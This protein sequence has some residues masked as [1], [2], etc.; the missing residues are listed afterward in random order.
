ML[1]TPRA[2]VILAALAA[3]APLALAEDWTAP[4]DGVVT[5]KHVDDYVAYLEQLAKFGGTWHARTWYLHTKVEDKALNEASVSRDEIVWARPRVE[6]IAGA[7]MLAKATPETWAKLE[8]RAQDTLAEAQKKIAELTKNGPKELGD[9]DGVLTELRGLEREMGQS[10]V[11]CFKARVG[12]AILEK[13]RAD[14]KDDATRDGLAA[15]ILTQRG[16][17][18]R[19]QDTVLTLAAKLDPAE[20]RRLEIVEKLE[21]VGAT[22]GLKLVQVCSD[23]RLDLEE[24]AAAKKAQGETKLETFPKASV[25]AVKAKQ[26]KLKKALAALGSPTVTAS[27]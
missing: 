15:K 13:E 4:A 5:A 7:L 10:S 25:D 18:D 9:L 23:A 26:E 24:I 8:K 6:E 11:E 14:A 22:D 21:K 20:R 16:H 27:R 19:A 1:R 12:L 3:L 2:L 17:L